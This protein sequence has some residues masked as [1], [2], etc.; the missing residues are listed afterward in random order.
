VG[1]L[2]G[3]FGP[4]VWLLAALGA[5]VLTAAAGLLARRRALPHGPAMCAATAAAVAL[6]VL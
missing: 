4:D 2:A 6:A 3:A 5:P 1:A